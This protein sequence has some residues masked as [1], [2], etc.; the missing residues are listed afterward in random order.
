[1]VLGAAAG[2]AVA[3]SLRSLLPTSYLTYP[4]VSSWWLWCIGLGFSGLSRRSE[5]ESYLPTGHSPLVVVDKVAR[6]I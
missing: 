4:L 2:A 3:V 5:E 1:M 6:D